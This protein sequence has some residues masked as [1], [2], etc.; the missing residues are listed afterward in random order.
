MN[1]VSISEGERNSGVQRPGSHLRRGPLIGPHLRP[2]QNGRARFTARLPSGRSVPD[3]NAL[4]FPQ[5][6]LRLQDGQSHRRRP[7]CLATGWFQLGKREVGRGGGGVTQHVL[8]FTFVYRH[9]G[10]D[11]CCCCIWCRWNTSTWFW[12]CGGS[13]VN[14]GKWDELSG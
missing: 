6:G 3:K 10:C 4:L 13:N 2:H 5:R 11:R 1:R 12:W 9:R 7:V 14:E 8:L